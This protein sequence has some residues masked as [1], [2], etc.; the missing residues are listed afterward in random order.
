M[1]FEEEVK[2]YL[3]RENI[4]EEEK[5]LFLF[6]YENREYEVEYMLSGNKVKVE[7][8]LHGYKSAEFEYEMD[9]IKLFEVMTS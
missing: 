8:I 2:N 4:E 1:K 7:V 5:G 3:S 9:E 6:I